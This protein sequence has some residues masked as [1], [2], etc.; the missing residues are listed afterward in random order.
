MMRR[1]RMH[2]SAFK[3]LALPFNAANAANLVHDIHGIIDADCN[4]MHQGKWLLA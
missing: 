1:M 4:L 2:C 3:L